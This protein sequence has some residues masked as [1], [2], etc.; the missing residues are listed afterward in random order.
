VWHSP[1]ASYFIK[2]LSTRTLPMESINN[3]N[4]LGVQLNSGDTYLIR[5]GTEYFDLMPV[6]DWQHVPGVT[7]AEHA[8][9]PK[10]LA[11]LLP[12]QD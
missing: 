12:A 5:N 8:V 11:A 10:R 1:E 7:W 9:A 4:Q 2:T 3:E 6:W